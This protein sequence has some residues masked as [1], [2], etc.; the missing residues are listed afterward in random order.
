MVAHQKIDSRCRET[1]DF[2]IV[3]EVHLFDKVFRKQN[4]V[5]LALRQVRHRNRENVQTVEQ[6][7]SEQFLFH[8]FF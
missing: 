2:L 1:T 7:F 6:V 5:T 8:E 4:N 3:L